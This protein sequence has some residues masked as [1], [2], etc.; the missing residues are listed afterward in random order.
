MIWIKF[1]DL[2]DWSFTTGTIPHIFG[3]MVVGILTLVN[4]VLPICCITGIYLYQMYDKGSEQQCAWDIMETVIGIMI[5]GIVL[6]FVK[7]ILW[8]WY[9]VL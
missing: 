5:I 9:Y 4:W 3:G 6:L 8:I 2:C 1:D 7:T